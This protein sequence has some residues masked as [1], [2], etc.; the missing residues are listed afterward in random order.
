M[1]PPSFS[2]SVSWVWETWVILPRSSVSV[3]GFFLIVTLISACDQAP[4]R[5]GN[6]GTPPAPAVPAERQK[7]EN[8]EQHGEP[9][10]ALTLSVCGHL[11]VA[12][13]V[14]RT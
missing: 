9:P 2:R 1:F 6:G 7:G 10:H 8:G 5:R 12:A 11:V 13:S 4:G 14:R 3:C